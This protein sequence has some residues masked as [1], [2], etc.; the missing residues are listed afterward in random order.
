MVDNLHNLK[1]ADASSFTKPYKQAD[2]TLIACS[3]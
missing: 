3:V 1:G 2:I